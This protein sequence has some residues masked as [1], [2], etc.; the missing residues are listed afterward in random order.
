MVE[1]DA[2]D[3]A[4][5]KSGSYYTPEELVALII[6]RAVGPLVADKVAKFGEKAK[7]LASDRRPIPERLIHQSRPRR[8]C[9]ENE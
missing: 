4:R 3:E 6:N 5:H 8:T 7:T 2:D 9:P 1:I